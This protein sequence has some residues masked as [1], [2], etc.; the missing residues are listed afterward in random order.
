MTVQSKPVRPREVTDEEAEFFRENGWVKLERLV[1]AEDAAILLARLREIMGAD[2]ANASHPAAE[3]DAKDYSPQFHYY[4]PLAVDVASGECVE[5]VFYD[6][7]HSPEMGRVGA[8]LAGGA[9]RYWV[10]GALVKMPAARSETGSSPTRWHA[11]VGARDKSPFDPPE[12]QMQ[13]WLAL[14]DIPYERGTMRFVAPKNRTEEVEAIA[15]GSG[16][17]PE[18]SYPTLE[19]MGVV[20][21]RN[22]MKAGDATVHSSATFHSA[23]ANTSDEPR[24]V[25]IVS[26]FPA[27]ARYSG[28]PFWVVDPVEG[29]EPGKPFVDYRFPVLA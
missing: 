1:S 26:M 10:D 9:V 28:N 12:G 8:K 11:D 24:W 7:S 29:L 25:Y 5:P 22:D 14:A 15:T 2:A 6:V 19:R 17:D 13:L 21:P 23:P 18:S 16:A 27:Q 3:G 20:S 4:E